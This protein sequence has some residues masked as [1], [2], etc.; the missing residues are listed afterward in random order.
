MAPAS[1][2]F[3]KAAQFIQ[4]GNVICETGLNMFLIAKLN[5]VSGIVIGAT[6]VLAMKQMC[7]R[8]QDRKKRH[9][10]VSAKQE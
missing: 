7:K 4:I 2:T 9:L 5:L 10:P 3:R 1:G 6:A 8:R